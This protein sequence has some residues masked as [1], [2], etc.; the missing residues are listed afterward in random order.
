MP[1]NNAYNRD[2]ANHL[3]TI[4]ERFATLYAYSPVDGRGGYEGGAAGVLFQTASASK[5]DGEDNM[6]NN[7]MD[8]PNVYH[9]G[10]DSEGMAGGNAF[11]KGTFRDT[12]FGESL[13][14]GKATGE[15]DKDNI[16][17]YGNGV[18]GAG[19]QGGTFW[20]TLGDIGNTA[21]KF[22][23]LLLALGKPTGGSHA[24]DVG[25]A[26]KE[27]MEGA[28][29]SG[30]NFWN[31]F[32]KGIGDV[33][34]VA[35]K[36]VPV[37]MKVFGKGDVGDAQITPNTGGKKRGR[38]KGSG[39]KEDVKKYVEAVKDNIAKK[40]KKGG[41]I[42]GNPDGYPRQGNSQ[43][44]A[45]RGRPKVSGKNGDLLAMSSPDLAN[46]TPP[47]AQL[48]GS[49]GGAKPKLTKE[50]KKLIKE[51]K[52]MMGKGEKKILPGACRMEAS[53]VSGGKGGR[54]KRAEIVKKIMKERGVKMIEASKIVKSEGLYKKE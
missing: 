1:Y 28:G 38:P 3:N 10:N 47:N 14:A 21:L 17:G 44:V 39:I 11:A 18:V 2:I 5:R 12:G 20:D 35:G 6:Y 29:L 31:D 46:G 50:E 4:N 22:A 45:G 9:Y 30:G 48:R 43:R 49:Y 24:E 40:E 8:L 7:Q 23:P 53:G 41:A 19:M 15:F 36:I 52:K 27:T 54:S 13:G 51:A 26:F 25:K 42:L 34:D 16:I 37:A 32:I 33:A